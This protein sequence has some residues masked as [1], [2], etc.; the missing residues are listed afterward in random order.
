MLGVW[1][2][3]AVPASSVEPPQRLDACGDPLPPHALARLGTL[4]WRQH[5]SIAGLAYS[6]DGKRLACQSMDREEGLVLWDAASGRELRRWPLKDTYGWTMA[7]SGDGGTLAAVCERDTVV[8]LFDVQTGKDKGTCTSANDRIY[9]LA[10]SP[11]GKRL[12][13]SHGQDVWLWDAA[14]GAELRLFK[15][16]GPGVA[17]GGAGKTLLI[18][19]DKRVRIWDIDTGKELRRLEG[20]AQRLTVS[21][22]GRT[23][24]TLGGRVLRLWDAATGEERRT[25]ETPDMML[26]E[27]VLSA[28][29]RTVAIAGRAYIHVWDATT[30]QAL[31][32]PG[33]E[34]AFDASVALSPDGRT[35]AWGRWY[36]PMIHRWDLTTGRELLT[37]PG[38]AS[39]VQ[40][41][42]FSPDGNTLA[43]GGA[44]RTVR[45]WKLGTPRLPQEKSAERSAPLQTGEAQHLLV[46][47]GCA[48]Y[49]PDGKLL[50]T[51][52]PDNSVSL[53][54]AAAGKLVRSLT[55]STGCN[56]LAFTPDGNIVAAGDSYHGRSSNPRGRVYL[57]EVATG[58]LLRTIEGHDSDVRSVA[59]SPDGK[60]LASGSDGVRLWETATGKQVRRLAGLNHFIDGLAFSP[61]GRHL[62]AGG[63]GTVV[64]E[65]ATGKV[66]HRLGAEEY[67]AG[68]AFAPDGK[69]VATGGQEQVVRLWDLATGTELAQLP[70]HTHRIHAVAFAP[71]GK[72]LASGSE[73]TTI[74]L[75]DVPA[76]LQAAKAKVPVPLQETDLERLWSD[77][78]KAD[79]A[80][81]HKAVWALTAEPERAVP[82]L[83]ARL[84]AAGPG[85]DKGDPPGLLVPAGDAL[86]GVRAVEVLEH[87]G[88]PAAREVLQTLSTGTASRLTR[89]AKAALE[90][91][92]QRPGGKP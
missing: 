54:E 59:F 52:G 83:K 2:S 75:W 65:V 50:A 16:A 5:G 71:D 41:V 30:G 48:V 26:G 87:I 38:H 31:P 42:A 27:V 12:A 80:A 25:L 43:S 79:A 90:R 86:R 33:P 74:L 1:S 82:L 44:D 81:G 47:G 70:G 60:V 66:K 46:L 64:W 56:C 9:R 45:F 8:R 22:D 28:N 67:V 17:F 77:L 29:G 76:A 40:S 39:H 35:L 84:K 6:A 19:N 73:D 57:W 58:R 23:L 53:Y 78:A 88:T 37:C 24:A 91:L 62:A 10:L 89:E 21:A 4:R 85:A 11:D 36:Q 18:G 49:A 69:I 32:R 92:D 20:A 15:R 55:G 13:T 14:K 51:P 72:T 61:D 34:P 7:L 68:L 63:D 3:L